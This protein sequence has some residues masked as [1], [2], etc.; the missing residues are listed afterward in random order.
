MT[1]EPYRIV[2]GLDFSDTALEALEAAV[3]LA[4]RH[5]PA[6]LHLAAVIDSDHA[7]LVPKE[8][9]HASLVQI[10]DE[11]RD[12]LS[13]VGADL[14][15]R[16]HQRDPEA[17]LPTSAHVRIGPPAEQIATLAMEIEANLV[18]VGTHGRRGVRRLLMGS[19]AE[20][21][22]RLAPCP[23]FVVRPCDFSHSPPS[24]VLEPPCPACVAA[25]KASQGVKWWCEEHTHNPDLVHVYS[26]SERLD[27]VGSVAGTLRF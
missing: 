22:V 2:V 15:A 23:V 7:E 19:V 10:A 25:R 8:R 17:Q 14:L 3:S 20:K 12:R 1:P 27:Y 5:P 11:V 24:P 9:R 4:E 21:T 6:E 16:L 18:V 13:R 26:R